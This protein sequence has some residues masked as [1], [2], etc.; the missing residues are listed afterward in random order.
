[1]LAATES[2]LTSLDPRSHADR[3]RQLA[4]WA[5]SAAD[6]A[7]VCA[8]LRGLGPYERRLALVAAMV[9][10]DHEGIAAAVRDP[11]PSIR[12]AALAA[13]LRAGLLPDRVAQLS[14]R[15]RRRV[16]RTLRRLRAPSIADAMI[17]QI[18][19]HFGDDE[20]A[21]V[22]PACSA[23]TVR[24]LL[25]DLSYAVDL[26]ALTRRHPGPVLELVAVE[27]AGAA[28]ADRD[29]RWRPFAA[30]VL[31][32]EP[33]AAL[34][35]I[36]RY[37]PADWLPQDLTGFGVLAGHDPGRVVRLLTRPERAGRLR[38]VPL[39]PALLRRL[40]AL[41][42]DDLVPLAR[43]VRGSVTRPA[44]LLRAVAPARRA[45]LYDRIVADQDPTAVVPAGEILETLP[46]AV[47]I[48][49]AN[50]ALGLAEIRTRPPLVRRWSALLAWP[51]ASAALDGA[52]RSG[53]AGERAHAYRLLVRAARCSRDS[54]VLAELVERLGRLRNE[55]DPVRS[56]ALT[57]LARCAP[58]LTPATAAGLTRLTTDAVQARD[59]SAT[60]SAALASLAAATLRDH[61][62]EP[63][64]TGWALDTVQRVCAVAATP[65]LPRLDLVLRRGQ[66]ATV[67]DRLG[68]WVEAAMDRG[69]YGPLFAL[70]RALGRR[71]R[72]LPVLQDLLRRA[73][74]PDTSEA[75]AR[76]AIPLWLDDPRHRG[77]RVGE[78]LAADRTAVTVPRV[79]EAICAT[80]TDLLDVV[81]G[82]PVRGRMVEAGARWVPG[83]PRHT[84]RWLPR[85]QS[86]FVALLAAVIDDPG[87]PVRTRAR[88]VRA[89]A[90]V[91][92]PGRELVR[93]HLT[94]GEVVIAEAALGALAATDRPEEA[95]A[96]L[97]E[98][99]DDD[100]A[101]VAVAAAGRAAGHVEPARLPALLGG[102]LAGPARVTSRKEAARLLGRYAPAEVM[103]T[104]LAVYADP[105][106]HRDV[107]AAIVS[108]ARR[109]L[110]T[111]PGWAVLAAA[112]RDGGRAEHRALLAAVPESM[113]GRHRS[114]YAAL[115]LAAVGNADRETR[116]V[117]F[118]ALRYWSAC[119]DR[120]GTLVAE[121][122]ADLGEIVTPADVPGLLPALGGPG[123]TDVLR[124][125]TGR[126]AAD[127]RPGGPAADRPARRR[128]ETLVE[129]VCLWARQAPPAV[130]RGPILA[131][132]RHLAAGTP[133][134]PAAATMVAALGGLADADELAELCTGRP[135]LAARVAELVRRRI[136]GPERPDAEAVGRA[137]A[138]LAARGDLAGGLLAVALIRDGAATRPAWRA[139]LL[140]LRRHPET[141][142]R[143]EAYAVALS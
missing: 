69:E 90:R 112:A 98:H 124:V 32:A 116:R 76:Q 20:A 10:G 26:A 30:A 13:A 129:G 133:F 143:D 52:L 125:L 9:A 48:R 5:R 121:R 86:A 79:W 141:E 131:A 40:A 106:T 78:V 16:Y 42:D 12:S 122:F 24:A 83:T 100:R 50:R 27:M 54:A 94:A 44:A 70:V 47:R 71:A 36:E 65:L 84:E 77:E 117:A 104:L 130:D 55:P 60:T 72:R 19:A 113:S 103:A 35:V 138:R 115:V 25:P 136:T 2:L 31:A 137:A 111:G 128:V 21:A 1:M 101:R 123:L 38:R 4:R 127:D 61:A 34:D 46:A 142:V 22:L 110:D 59:V 43:T 23:A 108:A 95:L 114:R 88:S 37:A 51:D 93:R 97:L 107:R 75:V 3:T 39:P 140:G 29:A 15:D 49:E 18:R 53:D 33:A 74:G 80:R 102:I 67:A 99:A 66:E 118:A 119:T 62:G 17:V 14:A 89:A 11:Q 109:R 6:R 41:P 81:L 57:E 8:E 58:L 96:V 28:P 139:E 85:Q 120:A 91:S 73:A 56:A 105:L 87:Q 82:A 45:A 68:G 7:E 135:V 92:G 63:A 134:R 132:A 64:L 126:D